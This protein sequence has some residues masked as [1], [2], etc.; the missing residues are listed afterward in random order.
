MGAASIEST[1]T[2]AESAPSACR[3]IF[4]AAGETAWLATGAAAAPPSAAYALNANPPTHKASNHFFNITNLGTIQ[5][6]H[7][8]GGHPALSHTRLNGLSPASPFTHAD[9]AA[10]AAVSDL[11]S[12]PACR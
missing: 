11:P 12:P 8:A 2:S 9:G 5:S 10:H 1:W 6:A 7:T 3:T 4:S